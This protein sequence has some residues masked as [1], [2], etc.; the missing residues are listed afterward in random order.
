MECGAGATFHFEP[1]SAFQ[2]RRPRVPL[3]NRD[4]I[5]ER[6]AAFVTALRDSGGAAYLGV[7][8]CAVVADAHVDELLVCD[9][10]HR[11]LALRDCFVAHGLDARVPFVVKRC[12]DAAALRAY[13]RDLNNVFISQDLVLEETDMV[14]AERFKAHLR[15]AFSGHVSHA[16]RPRFPNVNAD[17]LTTLLL[18]QVPAPR[19]YAAVRAHAD[20]LNSHVGAVLQASWP[21]LYA[22]ATKKQGLFL[23]FLFCKTDHEFARTAL[24]AAV[25]NATWKRAFPGS[26]QG[27]CGVCGCGI[28][29]FSFHAGHIVAAARGGRATVDNL[30][31]LC[32]CCNTSMGTMN[33]HEFKARFFGGRARDEA[34]VVEL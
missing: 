22:A 1:F 28:D 18:K 13:Y 33:V 3:C 24:P 30:M 15:D 17:A 6:V 23:A 27:A 11:F 12:A 9:G 34:A 16:A 7:L 26:T 20:A 10:Q 5:A 4:F 29:V 8:H 21:K 19:T 31:P 32:A 2:R 14:I 25:R